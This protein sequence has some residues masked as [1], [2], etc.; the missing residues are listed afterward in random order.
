M[1]NSVGMVEVI[2]SANAIYILDVML[3]LSDTRLELANPIPA[4]NPIDR[5]QSFAVDVPS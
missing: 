3:K 5:I 2:G 1:N 4:P